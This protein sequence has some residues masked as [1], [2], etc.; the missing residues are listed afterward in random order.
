[1]KFRWPWD[2]SDVDKALERVEERERQVNR[3]YLDA[4]HQARE[5]HIGE[6][7][8]NLFTLHRPESRGHK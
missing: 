2:H 7:L 4:R 3:I 5:N 1:M 8:E 6:T